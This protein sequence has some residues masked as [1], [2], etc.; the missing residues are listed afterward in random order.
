MPFS[1]IL[2]SKGSCVLGLFA[3]LNVKIFD[4]SSQPLLVSLETA[5][6]INGRRS[7][8]VCRRIYLKLF[9]PQTLVLNWC[10]GHRSGKG[11]TMD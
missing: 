7:F 1:K 5:E 10:L 9:N 4:T 2:E 11:G 8:F 3:L 6:P